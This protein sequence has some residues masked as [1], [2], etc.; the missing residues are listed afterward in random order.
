MTRYVADIALAVGTSTAVSIVAKTTSIM[1]ATL[2]GVRLARTTRA[3]MRHALLTA[4]LAVSLA[5]PMAS[6]IVPSSRVVRVPVMMGRITESSTLPSHR[7]IA[8]SADSISTPPGD[9]IATRSSR[10]SAS[11]LLIAGWLAGTLLYLLPVFVGLWQ[12]QGLTRVGL[13][14]QDG[15]AIARRFAADAH[16]H[17]SIEVR[18]HEALS[19][20]VS[21]GL[22]RPTIMLPTDALTWTQDDLSRAI[23]HELEHIRRCDWVSQCLARVACACYWFHP[24]VWGASRQIA[25]EAELACDDAVLQK[26]EATDYADQLVSLAQRMSISPNV[27]WIMMANRRD[28]VMRIAAVLDRRRR[29]GRIKSSSLTIVCVA[30]ALLVAALS[31]LRIA[32]VGSTS[33]ETLRQGNAAT[34]K[35]QTAMAASSDPSFEVATIK[36]SAPDERRRG[37]H[38]AGD[39]FQTANTSLMDLIRFAYGVQST[40]VIGGPSWIETDRFNILAKPDVPG[41]PNRA[42]VQIMLRKL[43]ADRFQ[44]R[45][46]RDTKELSVYELILAKNGPKLTQSPGDPTG[47]PTLLLRQPGLLPARNATMEDFAQWMQSSVLDRP[48]IDRTGLD[49]R[50]DFLLKWTPDESQFGGMGIHV[51]APTDMADAPPPLFTAIQEQMGLKL[52]AAKEQVE[53]LV[54]DDAKQPSSN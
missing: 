24:L 7:G 29:R 14:W 5:L 8:P 10:I 40:Q 52:Q 50:W 46:H 36:P 54:L 11:S 42:Q 6:I 45:L 38:V 4:A 13:V 37:F 3:A 27:A 41:S 2:V 18:L 22:M 48:V 51:P 17:R 34:E 20:P 12:L 39:E 30:S 35:T 19:G 31:P 47:R 28:L 1:V 32:A 16:I 26:T 53:V 23:T 25:L 33:R 21:F 15:R 9:K 44:L 49:G 43:L